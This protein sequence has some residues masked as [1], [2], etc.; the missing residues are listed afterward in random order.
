MGRWKGVGVME[1]MRE[2]DDVWFMDG[3]GDVMGDGCGVVFV[4]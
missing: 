1:G 2:E 3:G 4:V